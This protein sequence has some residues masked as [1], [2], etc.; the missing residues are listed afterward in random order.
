M[1]IIILLLVLTKVVASHSSISIVKTL[2]GFPGNLPFKL[3]TGYIGVD[4]LDNEQLF[5]YFIESERSPEDDPLMLWLIGGPGC[6]ALSALVYE[7]G[8][9]SFNYKKSRDFPT[10]VLNP[11]SWTK[12]ANI[13]FLDA[14]VGS[15]FSYAKSWQGFNMTDTISAAQTYSFLRKWLSNHPKFLKNQLYIA[16]DS[17]SGKIV[18]MIVQEI[19]DGIDARIEP[20]MNLKGY[21]LGNPVTDD[22]K[23]KNSRIQFAYLKALI[24]HE[25]YESAK[26]YCKGEY[27]NVDPS[28]GLCKL[29]LQNV[30]ECTENLDIANILEPGCS[31]Y[32]SPKPKLLTWDRSI[33]MEQDFSDFLLSPAQPPTSW[34]RVYNYYYSYE[35]A[36]DK[37]V[38][39]ALGV[40]EG[41]IKDWARC[42][43]SILY[44]E[45]VPSSL[46][47]HRN[48][49]KRGYRV[50]IYSGDLDMAVPYVGTETW[51]KSLNLTVESGWQP[52][53]VEGQ[54]AG[55]WM[56]YAEGIYS[57]TYATVKGGGHTAP[58]YK[59]K[60][61][62]AMISRW[63]AL[64]PL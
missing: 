53:S 49:I 19:S 41:T 47:Y 11:Y 46:Y 25:I 23:D 43:Q 6:S 27:T 42:N 64:Y 40:R 33:L 5:Y 61:C 38:Q 56:Q 14:P 21:V 37:T 10:F 16:G 2:P 36:N 1:H 44:T 13:I 59:P 58:E 50:L 52:W 20:I 30:T 45:D 12:V 26:T 29:Y 18:P 34:C 57:L 31:M 7:I 28:N 22:N 35:W 60:E 8:P 39:R 17:Y 51:I 32:A 9:L 3:E 54:V 4:D 63:L 15:G 48:L 24:T 62:L 55:Y